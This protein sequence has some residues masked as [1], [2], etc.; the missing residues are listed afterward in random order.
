MANLNFDA[1]QV[2]PQNT[3]EPL[4]AG[5]YL[6]MI[7]DSDV[8]PTKAG[9]GHYAQFTLQ[10]LE[11]QYQGRM[12]WD[13]IN[14]HNQNATAQEIGQKQL[15]ALCHAVGVL[16]VQDTTQL[17]DKPVVVRLGLK[18]D[19]QYG[20]QNEVKGYKQPEGTPAAPTPTGTPTPPPPTAAAT[21]QPPWMRQ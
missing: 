18:D 6:C 5:D 1:S 3:Y 11:G 2:D 20:P 19:R 17:H 10:V 15:S 12:I 16:Q 14:I 8:K 4:P 21:T 7:V 13:R 9:T